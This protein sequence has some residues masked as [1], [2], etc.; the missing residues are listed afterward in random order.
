MT[1]IETLV[2][3]L[4]LLPHPEGGFYVETYRS[5]E[6]IEAGALPGRFNGARNMA[7]AI[8][9]L[10]P[11]GVFSAFHRILSDETWHFYDGGPLNIYVIDPGGIL[12]VIRLGCSLKDGETYQA[13]V[14]AGCWFASMP[15][16]ETY[17]LVGCTVAPGFDFA[18][19]EL[20]KAADLVAVYPQHESLVRLLC[21]Q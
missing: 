2:R 8:Y 18:D 15:A 20:A 7:T 13:V 5:A 17:S 14:P 3:Q 16:A 12:Q 11:P 19:F 21:R 6:H 1:D 4:H 9:F 10:L